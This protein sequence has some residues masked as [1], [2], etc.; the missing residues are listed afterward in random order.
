MF[1]PMS[2][3]VRIGPILAIFAGLFMLAGLIASQND[4]LNPLFK[5]LFSLKHAESALIQ[6]VYFG[7]YVILPIPL[8]KLAERF[9]YRRCLRVALLVAG[10]GALIF[11][12]A[13]QAN[14]FSLF[15]AGV[16]VI[17]LGNATMIILGNPYIGLISPP[18][19]AAQRLNLVNGFY[20]VGTT[21]GPILGGL[22][23]VKQVETI[24]IAALGFPYLVFGA[25]L[26]GV[27]I[28]FVK[29]PLPKVELEE[30][31]AE[32]NS[33]EFSLWKDRRLL[34]GALAMFLY[35][36]AEVGAASKLV[37]W[38]SQA[39]I[40]GLSRSEASEYL[41]IYWGLTMVLRFAS[42]GLM[43][44]VKP[45]NILIFNALLGVAMLI[46]MLVMNGPIAGYA[47]VMLGAANAVMFPTIFALSTQHLGPNTQ[48]GSSYVLM[49]V[50]GGAIVPLIIGGLTDWQGLRAG[51]SF[52]LVCYGVIAVFGWTIRRK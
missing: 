8:S 21:L 22:L 17:A 6:F 3:K 47:I 51:L 43:K 4:L 25:M 10:M 29:A 41:T 49:A 2:A 39:D 28:L 18:E 19:K 42:V 14:A 16:M 27:G 35:V 34:L 24:G 38:L 7:V 15:L 30:T 20:M 36:G 31:Q 33:T 5:E 50:A 26:I 23:Y 37:D 48:R 13:S 9:G 1:A 12:L 11:Y 44:W 46:I 40:M 45:V 32:G 52:L